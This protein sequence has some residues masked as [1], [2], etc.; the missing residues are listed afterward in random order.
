MGRGIIKEGPGDA[1]WNSGSLLEKNERFQTDA[2]WHGEVLEDINSK[3]DNIE[4]LLQN[5]D[6]NIEAMR[7]R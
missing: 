7:W 4:S 1:D 3:Q 5:I 6:Q 2:E